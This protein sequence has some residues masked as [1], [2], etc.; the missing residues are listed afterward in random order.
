M[1]LRRFMLLPIALVGFWALPSAIHAAGRVELELVTEARVPLTGQQEWLRRL[2]QVGVGNLRIRTKRPTDKPR[3][4]V[5]GRE[6]APIYVV[7][8]VIT[9]N[10]ELLVPG[11]RFR[12][13]EVDRLAKWLDDL[14]RNGPADQREPKSAFGLDGQQYERVRDDLAQPVGFST[15]AMDR[16]E[17]VRR[18]GVRLRLPLRFDPGLFGPMEEDELAEELMGL[19]CGTALAY[20]VRPLGL[21]LAPRQV[22]VRSVEHTI[23]QARP[24]VEA[25]PVGWESEKPTREVLPALHEFLNVNVQGVAVTQV[26]EA[27]GKRLKVPVLLDYNAMARHGVEPDKA[28]VNL[29]Q[30]RTTHSLLLRKVLFQA[31]LKSE[32]RVDEAGKPFLWVTTIKPL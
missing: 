10:S 24:K 4:Q 6:E 5:Q 14:A 3:I 16:N 32:L 28:L 27:V 13:G 8:G 17:V 29:P 20:T 11:G 22:G 30:T 21:C 7:T 18:I 26:L 1:H 23:V 25:W 9:S 31:K 2:A 15:E 19:S 12:P